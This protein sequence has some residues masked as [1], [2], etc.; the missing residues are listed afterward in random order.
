MKARAALLGA[1]LVVAIVVFSMPA[2]AAVSVGHLAVSN[3]SPK[4]A[5]TIDVASNGWRPGGVVSISLSGT[6]LA[7]TIADAAGAVH[8]EVL[9]PVHSPPFASLAAAGSAASA[10]RNRSSRT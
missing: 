7:R 2:G 1:A 4:R 3:P 10:C 9:I 5:S 6:V 8:A